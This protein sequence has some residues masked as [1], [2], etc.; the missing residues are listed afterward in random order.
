MIYI[1]Y[2][3]KNISVLLKKHIGISIMII[4]SEIATVLCLFFSYGLF[5]NT[6]ETVGQLEEDYYVYWYQAS[7]T[8]RGTNGLKSKFKELTDYLGENFKYV[9]IYLELKLEN[10]EIVSPSTYLTEANIKELEKNNEPVLYLTKEYEH[11]VN[12]G[13]ITIEGKKYNAVVTQKTQENNIAI[14]IPLSS[15][16][17]EFYCKSF[18]LT[19]KNRP[20]KQS[21]DDLNEKCFELFSAICETSPE[22][23]N[24]L[25]VQINNSF[26][27]Y[28][29]L[30][31]IIVT[32]NLS[33]FFRYILSLRRK[34]IHV[35]IISGAEKS[36]V[37]MLFT[38]EAIISMTIAYGVAY[39]LYN[40][41]ILDLLARIYPAFPSYYTSSFFIITMLMYIAVT[42]IILMIMYSPFIRKIAKNERN[43]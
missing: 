40:S 25:E 15:L 26:Y 29:F 37:L 5:Y 13:K 22:P 19:V 11:L 6:Q 10:G 38:I 31:V 30:I 42:V 12:D 33:V 21:I 3:W 7:Q 23:V 32:L 2:I 20:T 43:V 34:M 36:S 17:D 8:E 39:L 27:L 24:L 18:M 4:L 41:I 35:F 16:N 28:T 1:K 9:N 14:T